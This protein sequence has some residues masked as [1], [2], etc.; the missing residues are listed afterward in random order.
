MDHR[1]VTPRTSAG[2]RAEP[3]TMAKPDLPE[4]DFTGTSPPTSE[5]LAPCG[6]VVEGLLSV[7]PVYQSR[8]APIVC[9]D[10]VQHGYQR[11]SV[12]ASR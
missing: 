11:F 12:A 4:P 1:R 9:G 8:R 7:M 5:G 2:I 3:E 6:H 10:P